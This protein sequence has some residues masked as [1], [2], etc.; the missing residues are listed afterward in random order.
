[1]PTTTAQTDPPEPAEPA[2]QAES[3]TVPQ[4]LAEAEEALAQALARVAEARARL[5]ATLALRQ[6][7]EAALAR[8]PP[9]TEAGPGA[10][11]RER[12]TP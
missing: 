12:G 6:R 9:T 8:R 11:D 2:G 4:T 3:W 7:T 10:E 1:M 5:Q